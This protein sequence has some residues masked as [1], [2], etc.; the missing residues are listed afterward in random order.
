M[1]KVIIVL[2][3]ILATLPTYS[4]GGAYP[5]C[6]V[7]PLPE[8]DFIPIEASDWSGGSS[9]A[10]LQHSTDWSGVSGFLADNGATDAHLVSIGQDGNNGANEVFNLPD[11]VKELISRYRIFIPAGQSSWN[12]GD[13][14]L[15]LPG[16]AGD[17]SAANGGYG[18]SQ[19]ST[20]PHSDRAWS[21]RQQLSRPD[22]HAMGMELYWQGSSNSSGGNEFGDT[23]WYSGSGAIGG[24][25]ALTPGTWSEVTVHIKMNDHNVPN[26]FIRTYLDGNL[27]FAKENFEW[28]KAEDMLNVDRFWFDVYHGGGAKVSPGNLNVFFRGFEYKI[29]N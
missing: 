25:L 18:G 28:S 27:G 9:A 23:E 29:I 16:P 21:A 19:S 12:A 13:S 5:I 2:F 11:G 26:G 1:R 17:V 7:A 3:L 8:P 15:K 24:A 4:F 20:R 10:T 14:N 22:S 6:T